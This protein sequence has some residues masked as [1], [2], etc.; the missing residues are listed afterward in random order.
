[1]DTPPLLP[2]AT[3]PASMTPRWIAWLLACTVLPALPFLANGEKAMDSVAFPV[4]ILFALT[5]QL[6]TS[7]WVGAGISKRRQLG[8]GGIIG[9]GIVFMVAS[10]AVGTGVFFVACLSAAN[11]NFH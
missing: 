2:P 1:M 11:F 4:L 5:V 10:V 7:L 8:V 3:L 6:A 9:L